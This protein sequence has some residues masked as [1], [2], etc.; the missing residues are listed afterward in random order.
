M[1]MI[2]IRTSFS[3]AP[4]TAGHAPAVE[5]LA[6]AGADLA[7]SFE[8]E[9]LG[10]ACTALHCAAEVRPLPALSSPLPFLPRVQIPQGN[11]AKS[12]LRADQ[13][14]FFSYILIY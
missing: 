11:D 7:R 9:E 12:I 5:A 13:I 2:V 14:S 10:A 3:S 4:G 1:C 8:H 6:A